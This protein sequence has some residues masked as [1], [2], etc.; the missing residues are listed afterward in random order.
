ML[1]RERSPLFSISANVI[2]L[3]LGDSTIECGDVRIENPGDGVRGVGCIGETEAG[4]LEE[5]A[6][7]SEGADVAVLCKERTEVGEG[8]LTSEGRLLST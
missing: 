5:F 1:R 6:G 4:G 3:R 2:R 8:T 7:D